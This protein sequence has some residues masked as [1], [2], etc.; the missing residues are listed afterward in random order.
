MIS[1]VGKA[2]EKGTGP[3]LMLCNELALV[4]QGELGIECEE[5]VGTTVSCVLPVKPES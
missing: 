5:G 4:N 1:T 2:N 3:G